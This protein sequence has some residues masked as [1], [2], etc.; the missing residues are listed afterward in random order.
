MR[1]FMVLVTVVLFTTAMLVVSMSPAL[2]VV[3]RFPNMGH[4]SPRW[5]ASLR[6]PSRPT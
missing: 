3:E 4:P 1:R 2:A 5:Y 6:R